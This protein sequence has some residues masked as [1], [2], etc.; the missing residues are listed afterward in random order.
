MVS[1]HG[2][3][4]VAP[5][6]RLERHGVT[7]SKRQGPDAVAP[8]RRSELDGLLALARTSFD[9]PV[10]LLDL[11]EDAPIVAAGCADPDLRTVVAHPVFCGLPAWALD[12]VVVED[13]AAD[14]RL[15]G[16]R[17]GD[18]GPA[19]RFYAGVPVVLETGRPIASLILVDTAPR[20]FSAEQRQR[21]RDLARIVAV[22]LVDGQ[23][24][25]QVG[26]LTDALAEQI[27][28]TRREQVAMERYRKM[29]ERTSA[30][31]HIGV[32]ECDL[33][34]EQLTWTNGVY[35]IFELPRGSAVTRDVILS[36]YERTS[37]LRMERM[38][39][40]AIEDCSSCSLDIRVRT[41]GGLRRWVRLTIDVETENGRPVRIFGLKQ[42]I[43]QEKDLLERLRRLAEI[44][45][46][47]GLAN[48]SMFEEKLVRALSPE[49][50]G[51]PPAAL[52]LIDLDGFKELNDTFGHAAGDACLRE[53]GRRL[54]AV[55]RRPHAI[56][57]IGGDEF[58]VLV[59]GRRSKAELAALARAAI[60]EIGRPV[61]FEG[62]DLV[63]GASVGVTQPAEMRGH[64]LAGLFAAADRAMYAAKR[65]GRNTLRF[66]APEGGLADGP[67][68]PPCSRRAGASAA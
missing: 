12:V 16:T 8:S 25:R 32:W 44:D 17:L 23:R 53:I 6:E 57:R 64:D 41:V 61:P 62:N 48:R 24:A 5:P 67:P 11:A 19:I 13:V 26:A 58:A 66:H 43:T 3:Q 45:P 31:G 15:A 51:A 28:R 7:S 54:R 52:A 40:K 56:G 42:D 55:F 50:R 2:S 65:A 46:M 10:V 60:A 29:Y 68:E 38:R 21:L 47:T 1:L 4:V 22:L 33:A 9:V 34:T 35:D 49:S 36:L 27:E 59:R 37:R 30:F 14:P 39:R 63:V 18:G 20:L